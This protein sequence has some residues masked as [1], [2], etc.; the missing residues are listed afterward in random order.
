MEILSLTFGQL[1][2]YISAAENELQD[3][4]NGV[5]AVGWQ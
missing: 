1:K 2:M 4:G 3:T 5:A